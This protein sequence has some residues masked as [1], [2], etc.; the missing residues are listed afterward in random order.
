MGGAVHRLR[1]AKVALAK[2][3]KVVAMAKAKV[4][5]A[6]KVMKV[7]KAKKA[8]KVAGTRKVR[9]IG[10]GY[11][12]GGQYYQDGGARKSK[13]PKRKVRKVRA[14]KGGAGCSAM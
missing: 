10:G 14:Q 3:K 8:K 11:E 2:A 4:V 6:K 9:K 7:V 12:M 1:K 5:K 13:S